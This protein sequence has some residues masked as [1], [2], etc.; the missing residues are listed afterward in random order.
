MTDIDQDKAD[1]IISSLKASIASL[2]EAKTANYYKIL[3]ESDALLKATIPYFKDHKRPILPDGGSVEYG[4]FPYWIYHA[5]EMS[6]YPELPQWVKDILAALKNPAIIPK[7][8]IKEDDYAN[9][10]KAVDSG[11]AMSSDGTMY[12]WGPYQQL[13]YQWLECLVNE[14]LSYEYGPAS[15][16]DNA[17]LISTISDSVKI[18]IIGDW[19]TGEGFALEVL[20]SMMAQK[21]DIVIHLGDVYYSGSPGLRPYWGMNNEM[22]KF[23]KHW[24]QSPWPDTKKEFSS[25]TLNSN[26]EMYCGG[27]GYFEDALTAPVFSQQNGKSYFLLENDN[28]QIFGLD[29][30]YSSQAELYMAGAL[31]EEQITFMSTNRKSEKKKIILSHHTAFNT[32]GECIVPHTGNAVSE[33]KCVISP[34]DDA[35]A[36]L[37][38]DVKKGLG[39][40]PDYWYWGH[41]HDGIVYKTQTVDGVECHMR[42]SGDAAIPHG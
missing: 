30:A 23:I 28:W 15:F 24:P 9:L 5:E 16:G 33:G 14:F 37:W 6:F 36:S 27:Y 20:N 3:K 35:S 42:C 11:T 25:F 17:P 10:I 32:S 34:T 19:G 39:L 22:D 31:N 7:P 26:H 12:G 13:N 38:G 1:K 18:G 21:P 8:T 40:P 2:S 29:S 41:T 4:I